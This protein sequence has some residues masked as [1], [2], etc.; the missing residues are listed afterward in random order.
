MICSSKEHLQF[1]RTIYSDVPKSSR[2]F[3]RQTSIF[4]LKENKK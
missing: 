2:I 3:G 4:S 1:Y